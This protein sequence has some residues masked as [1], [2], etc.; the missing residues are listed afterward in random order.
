MQD[1][2]VGRGEA[3]HKVVPNLEVEMQVGTVAGIEY[4]RGGLLGAAGQQ[5]SSSLM[6]ADSAAGGRLPGAEK[7]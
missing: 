3:G 1:V 6:T 7:I 4:D 2:A 5:A